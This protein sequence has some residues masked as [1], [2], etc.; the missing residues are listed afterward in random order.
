MLM[1]YGPKPPLM[2]LPLVVLLVFLLRQFEPS[3]HR[4][5]ESQGAAEPGG[6]ASRNL[7]PARSQVSRAIVRR[8]WQAAVIAFTTFPP[9]GFYSMRLLWKLGQRD[10]PLSRADNWRSWTAF[11]LDVVAILYCLAFA[12]ALLIAFRTALA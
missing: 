9:L 2:L 11:F 6:G 7:S 8:A 12:V 3:S 4:P 10:T 1:A 5:S